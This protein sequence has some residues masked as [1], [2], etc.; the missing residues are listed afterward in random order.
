VVLFMGARVALRAFEPSEADTVWR[1]HQDPA[2][3]RWPAIP[4]RCTG[5]GAGSRPPR[6]ELRD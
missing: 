6:S 2:V 5:S 3:V 1:W 4:G